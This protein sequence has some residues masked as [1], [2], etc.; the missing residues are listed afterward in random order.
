MA[1]PRSTSVTGIE[2]GR[3]VGGGSMEVSGGERCGVG[4]GCSVNSWKK[5][6]AKAWLERVC[7]QNMYVGV[8][9]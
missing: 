2:A 3:V 4:T 6:G 5:P 8:L 9:C 7:L 1:P